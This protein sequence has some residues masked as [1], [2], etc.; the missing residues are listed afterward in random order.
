V[1][2]RLL[3]FV[4]GGPRGHVPVRAAGVTALAVGVLVGLVLAVWLSG[5]IVVTAV[6]LD[7]AQGDLRHFAYQLSAS[8]TPSSTALQRSVQGKVDLAAST[9]GDP[10]WRG[11]EHLPLLGPNLQS[12][13]Q[14]SQVLDGVVRSAGPLAEAAE[15]LSLKSLRPSTGIDLRPLQRMPKPYKR[16]DDAVGRA[17]VQAKAIRTAGTV[18]ALHDQVTELQRTL[19]QARPASAEVRKALPLAY[20]ILGGY[21]RRYYLLMFQNNAEE[22]ASGGN[23]AAIALLKVYKGRLSLDRQLNS[24]EFPHPFPK[25]VRSYGAQ[26]DRIYGDH[27]GRYVTNTTFTPDF[28]TTASLTR[29]MWQKVTKGGTVD[30]VISFD[31]VALSYLLKATGPITLKG[32][33]VIDSKNAVSYLLSDVYALHPNVKVQNQIFS[34]AAASIF[35][36]VTRGQGG[37]TKYF[38]QVPR[39][40]EEQRLK[41]WSVRASEQRLLMESPLGT[42]LPA[43][44]RP[45]TVLGVY[46]NDD[47]T[48]KMSF[49]MDDRIAVSVRRCTAAVPRYTVAT[50]VTNRLTAA[51]AKTVSDFVLAHQRDIPFGG[52]RQWVQL[53]GPVGSKLIGAF[54]D[55]KRVVWGTD[56]TAEKNTN[57]EATGADIRRPAVKGRLYG[58]PVGTVSITIPAGKSVTVRG[59]FTGGT[60]PSATTAVSHTPRVRAVPVTVRSVPCE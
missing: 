28:P 53:Y 25:A 32:G 17:A 60:S 2:E 40:L 33:D 18:G 43:D 4:H 10:V 55:G 59:I 31:P 52:D 37:L 7:Q 19:I 35:G 16:F 11:A 58:R 29:T 46:N 24:S 8:Q 45:K 13:R 57:P 23:P 36:A 54:I 49:Y 26:Y 12:L 44:N 9:A 5:R 51:K 47:A 6:A 41:A 22:R 38:A 20:S 3:A 56:I 48:S 27:V 14:T 1:R 21:S 39:M 50:T 30:G 34:S 15:G 42:M